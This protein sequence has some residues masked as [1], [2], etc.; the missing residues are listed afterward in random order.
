[1]E[2]LQ[3]KKLFGTDGIRGKA[4]KFPLDDRTVEIIGRSLTGLLA[5]EIGRPPAII[6]GRDTRESG[7]S[8][9]SALAG[10]ALSANARVESA[11]IITTPGVAYIARACS[12]DAGIVIS[13]SHNPFF[14]NGIKVFSPSGRK[15]SDEVE[16]IIEHDI[17]F[18]YQNGA[19]EQDGAN[20]KEN[21]GIIPNPEYCNKY[22]DHLVTVIG[23]SLD[24]SNMKIALDCSNGAASSIAPEVFTRLGARVTVLNASPDGKNINLNCGSLHTEDLQQT[25]Q[26]KG[27]DIGIAFDGDADR[28]LFVNSQG[29]LTDGDHSMFILAERMKATGRLEGN[30]V[31]ATVMSNIG[32]EIA[33]R[34]QGIEL[35]RAQVG[36]RYVLEELLARGA[37]LGGE[38]SGHLIFPDISL[39]G[40]GIITA[41]ELLGAVLAS[42]MTLGE[43]ACKLIR[44]PQILVNLEVTSK[45]PFETIPGLVEE[46]EKVER[47]MNGRGRTLVR[48][49]G[50]EN[51]ARVMVEGE[52]QKM[53]EDQAERI[54]GFIRRAIGRS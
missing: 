2:P 6:I 49:S 52:D 54:A 35:V 14:D 23:R 12:F 45:P 21:V 33:L 26:E 22:I 7:Q 38:Q 46:I 34:E 47:E 20:I 3:V 28:A 11:G 8:I 16:R 48:Y 39:A 18:A 37:K 25:V 15:L 44:F 19:F 53:I 17:A 5:A 41:I 40:D 1:M 30:V 43:L 24:L 13:A 27:L 42:G 36:D 10:G 31:V 50:T 4:Y 9:E 51:L 32:F 29:V